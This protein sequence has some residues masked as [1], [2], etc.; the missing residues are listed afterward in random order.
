MAMDKK[1]YLLSL[2]LVFLAEAP[3]ATVE[4]AEAEE[5]AVKKPNLSKTVSTTTSKTSKASNA[6][7]KSSKTKWNFSLIPKQ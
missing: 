1:S 7:W 4:V 2:I 6:K 3:K 5:A